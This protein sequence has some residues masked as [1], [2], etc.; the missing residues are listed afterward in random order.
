[1]FTN[2][3]VS[4]LVKISNYSNCTP[5][6]VPRPQTC[7]LGTRL[8]APSLIVLDC[9]DS[10][11]VGTGIQAHSWLDVAALKRREIN[12]LP[13]FTSPVQS[14]LKLGFE[15]KDHVLVM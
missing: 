4:S 6:L 13:S 2:C 15:W 11:L 14:L 9:K 1:M 8:L 12:T 10:P 3:L 7:V 5:S